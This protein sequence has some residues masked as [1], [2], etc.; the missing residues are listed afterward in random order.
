MANQLRILLCEDEENI[1]NILVELLEK[2]NFEV[3]HCRDGQQGWEHFQQKDYDLCLLDVMMPQKDGMTL[4]KEIRSVNKSMP[5]IF[6]TAMG[7]RENILEGFHAGA[8]DYITKPFNMEEL[9]LR[10]EALLRRAGNLSRDINE[11]QE[12]YQLGK[13][14]FNTTTQQ[15]SL[16]EHVIRLTT[17]ESELLTL[18]CQFANK[19]LERSHALR[20]IWGITETQV[21]PEHAFS[22]RSMDVYVTKLRR[23][24]DLD[25][26]IEIKNVHGK[27]YKLVIPPVRKRK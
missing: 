6:L 5:V 3:D 10:I 27:G 16:G 26:T 19:T 7:M 11:P 4:A 13:Y 15:L 2:H 18:L 17:K 1:G 21:D 20:E 12:T 24:L 8:D 23:M 9:V 25:P 14:S 22:Q